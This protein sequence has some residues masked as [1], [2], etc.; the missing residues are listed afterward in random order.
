MKKILMICVV[1][2]VALPLAANDFDLPPGKWW[3]NQRLVDHVG[4]TTEQQEQIRDLVYEHARTMIDLKADVEKAGL[5]LANVVN[6]EDFDESAVRSS[7]TAFQAA[8]HKLENER[9]EML[10]AV[11]K[12]LTTEQ[13]QKMQDLRTR[14]QQNRGPQRRPGQRSQGGQRPMGERPPGGFPR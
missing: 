6:T 3:E 7:Y 13:W 2:A 10:V 1:L 14:A 12:T 8:R 4:I 11:R 5:D 9:F